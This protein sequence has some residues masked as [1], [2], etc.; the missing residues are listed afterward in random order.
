MRLVRRARGAYNDSALR[1]WLALPLAFCLARVLQAD[2]GLDLAAK[3]EQLARAGNSAGALEV[4]A[5]ASR[6]TTNS[7]LAEDRIGFLYQVLGHGDEAI[8][9]FRAAATKNPK[10]A[11]AHY[12]LGVALWIAQLRVAALS[13]LEEAVRLAPSTFDYRYRL[14]AAYFDLADFEKAAKELTEA[15]KLPGATAEAWNFLGRALQQSHDLGGASSAYE[16]AVDMQPGNDTYRR[17]YALMLTETRHA[18]ESI[19]EFHKIL[20]HKPN[21][22]DAWINIGYAHLKLGKYDEAAEDFRKALAGDPNSPAAHYDLGIA[23]KMTDQIDAAQKELT[24]A[25]QLDPALPEARYTLGI[26]KWQLGDFAGTIEQMRAAIRLRPDYAEAHYT[27]GIALRQSGDLDGA[28]AELREAIRL[29]PSTP[30]P[31]NSLGQI[32]RVK[33]DKQGS[34]EAFAAGARLKRDAD[35]QLSNTLE[36]GM[37]GGTMPNPIPSGRPSSQG[38][39]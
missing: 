34:Q 10:L 30:G 3:A 39:E 24:E 1:I 28:M 4:L 13:E 37:R 23:L 29:D 9:H 18:D 11:V 12:H 2:E 20:Q 35:A 33:G 26:T 16:H 27:L 25:I 5:E 6:P 38:R 21:N 32:L 15:T 17:D 14:G 36:Q 7:A 31:Y 22:S 19:A 8:R